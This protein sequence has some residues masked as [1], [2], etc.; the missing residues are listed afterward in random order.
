MKT[1]LRKMSNTCFFALA[2][3]RWLALCLG[4]LIAA[5]IGNQALGINIISQDLRIWGNWTE[6]WGRSPVGGGQEES[7]S[8]SFNAST[9]V[10]PSLSL[11]VTSSPHGWCSA[12]SSISS[13]GCA[14]YAYAPPYDWSI[15]GD[16]AIYSSGVTRFYTE[17]SELTLKLTSYLDFNYTL[18]SGSALDLRLTLKDNTTA[19]TLLNWSIEDS[20]MQ[21]HPGIRVDWSDFYHFNVDPSHEYEFA[22]DGWIYAYSAKSCDMWTMA[23]LNPVPDAGGTW[24]LL[25]AS[26]AILFLRKQ[27]PQL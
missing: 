3:K 9:V 12:R 10:D 7:S 13:F 1:V 20:F 19:L 22:I 11:D 24:L 16:I 8:G 21:S 2:W 18:T 26:L 17:G 25:V 15:G 23:Q 27:L 5:S 6:S 4:Y 14:M